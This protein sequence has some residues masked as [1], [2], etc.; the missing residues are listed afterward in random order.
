MAWFIPEPLHARMIHAPLLHVSDAQIILIVNQQLFQTRLGHVCQLQLRFGRG[1]RSL[2]TLRYI[3]FARPRRLNHLVDG[4]VRLLQIARREI[5]GYVI[6]YLGCFI[7]PQL[8]VTPSRLKKRLCSHNLLIFSFDNLV[9][10][11]KNSRHSKNAAPPRQLFHRPLRF[12]RPVRLGP[13]C[14]TPSSR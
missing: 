1:H 13:T 2:A 14:P 6:D 8:P 11:T 10:Y 7:N 9:K 3:L 12:L 5:K 4:P